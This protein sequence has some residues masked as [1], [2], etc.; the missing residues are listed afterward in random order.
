MNGYN[1]EMAWLGKCLINKEL[2]KDDLIIELGLKCMLL[3]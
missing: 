3:L 2:D 1:G